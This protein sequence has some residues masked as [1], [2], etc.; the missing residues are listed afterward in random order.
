MVAAAHRE[1]RGRNCVQETVC[2]QLRAET[3]QTTESNAARLTY[4]TTGLNLQL[5]PQDTKYSY[6]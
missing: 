6:T 2:G 3:K 5:A 1:V 4:W